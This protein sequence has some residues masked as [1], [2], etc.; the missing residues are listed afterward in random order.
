MTPLLVQFLNF[1]SLVCGI[2][3]ARN[4]KQ[5]SACVSRPEDDAGGETSSS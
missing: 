5:D 4:D 1:G 2:Q 3:Q